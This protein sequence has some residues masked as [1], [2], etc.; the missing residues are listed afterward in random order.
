[1]PTT[2]L[3]AK[4]ITLPIMEE[5]YSLQGE[6][7]HTG[8]AAYFLRIGGCDVGC[9]FCD[10]KESWNADLHPLVNVDKV[11]ENILEYKANTVVITGGEPCLYNLSYLC[12]QI[13][14]HPIAL[15]LET[16]GSEK[17]SGKWDWICF[18]PKKKTI[19]QP[20]F[21]KQANE[22]KVIIQQ[23]SDLLWAEE[24]AHRILHPC[25]L[26]LQ[27]E[28]SQREIILPQIIDYILKHP[29]WKISLQSHKYM[30]IP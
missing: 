16:S 23:A 26:F 10:V 27:P 3:L 15:H 25:E 7:F 11:I 28:W 29:T 17:L 4:G 1:M 6:G 12:E 21:Y 30:R 9:S 22:M 2:D 24:N 20:E 18:S 5:F 13:S 8:K 19:I 14:K